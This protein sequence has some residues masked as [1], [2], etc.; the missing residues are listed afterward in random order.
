MESEGDVANERV[1]AASI[2]SVRLWACAEAS[3][4]QDDELRRSL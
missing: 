4:G 2:E 3:V 1:A